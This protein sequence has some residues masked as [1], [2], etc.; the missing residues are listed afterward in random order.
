M[1][2]LILRDFDQDEV[3]TI[4]RQDISVADGLLNEPIA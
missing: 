4:I 2:G 1:R 3:L